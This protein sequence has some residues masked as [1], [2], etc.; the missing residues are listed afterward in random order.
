MI[1]KKSFKDRLL[2]ARLAMSVRERR[3]VEQSELDR[4]VRVTPQAWSAWEAGAEPD[5]ERLPL[6]AAALGTTV[7]W[8]VA[9]E[10]HPQRVGR[11][12]SPTA[13]ELVERA[14]AK[15]KLKDA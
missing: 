11:R 15:R 3:T 10:G 6:I 2:D 1:P 9:G 13:D 14:G 4:E 8:L 12:A 5:Y 7:G